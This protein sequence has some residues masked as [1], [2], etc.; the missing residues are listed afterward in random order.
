MPNH[1]QMGLAHFCRPFLWPSL[2][3]EWPG[4]LGLGA[5]CTIFRLGGTNVFP[6][7]MVGRVAVYTRMLEF[8]T[9][10]SATLTVPAHTNPGV[11]GGVVRPS[12]PTF[13]PFPWGWAGLLLLFLGWNGDYWQPPVLPVNRVVLVKYNV[14]SDASTWDQSWSLLDAATCQKW[15]S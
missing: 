5:A 8:A 15:L 1:Y 12:S 3:K 6:A 10:I 14:H 9:S 11:G 7:R 2:W 13:L 4:L